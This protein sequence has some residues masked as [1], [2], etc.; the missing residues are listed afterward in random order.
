LPITFASGE[1][2]PSGPIWV[3]A[4]TIGVIA[5]LVLPV[6]AA[7]AR[8]AMRQRPVQAVDAATG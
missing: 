4:A 6:T 3:Y 1:W 8:I 5:L 7:A 2:L